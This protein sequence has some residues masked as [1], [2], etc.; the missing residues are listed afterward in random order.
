MNLPFFNREQALPRSETGAVTRTRGIFYGWWIVAAGT[1]IWVFN[2]MTFSYGLSVFYTSIIGDLGWTRTQLAGVISLSRLETGLMGG[3]DGYLVDKFGPRP[4]MLVGVTLMSLGF[5][6]LSMVDSLLMFYLVFIF[7]VGVGSS[8]S[9]VVP[10]DTTVANWFVRKRGTAFGFLRGAIAVGA[11]GVTLLALIIGDY[12]WRTAFVGVGVGTF[13]L[14][15]PTALVMRRRPEYY[16]LR[17]DGDPAPEAGTFDTAFDAAATDKEA[18]PSP[19]TATADEEDEEA[20]GLSGR[21]ALRTKAFWTISFGFALR[22]MV[23]GAVTLHAIP[24]VEDLGYSRTLAASVLGFIG[25][26]SL[27]GRLGGGWLCDLLGTKRVVVTTVLTLAISALVLAFAQTLW[28]VILFVAIYAPSYGAQAAAM[29]AIRADHFGRRSFG[30]IT[31]LSGMIQTGGS[32]IGPFFAAYVYDTTGSY[33][34][35]FLIFAALLLISAALF[36][37]LGRPRYR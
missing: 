16:G 5:I 12:G 22:M 13:A 37:S 7:L 6:A 4:V 11:L 14:G 31:G 29:P 15:I 21:Q 19:V 32:V 23:T 28:M 8:L 20:I 25:I 2:G 3:I 17:P 33:Q 35:A 27:T 9:Y 1:M 30:V 18:E 36:L 24:I 10:I 26:T 34:I